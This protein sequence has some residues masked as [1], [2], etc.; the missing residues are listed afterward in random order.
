[1]NKKP[2]GFL[3]LLYVIFAPILTMGFI[4]LIKEAAPRLPSVI[5]IYITGIVVI[6]FLVGS[7]MY[8]GWSLCEP[9]EFWGEKGPPWKKY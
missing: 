3:F 5:Q 1:M 4:G 6:A 7:I 2:K 8:L 9:G